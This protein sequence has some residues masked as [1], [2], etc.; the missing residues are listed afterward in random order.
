M[1]KE[2]FGSKSVSRILL[3]LFV[4]EKCYG[5][6]IQTLLQTSLT[7]VQ[8][9]LQRLEKD[10]IL[11]S[12]YEG[13]LR[14]YQLNPSYPLKG[15][16]EMLLKKA[17]RFLSA[18]EKKLY[19]FI[20]K[21]RAAPEEKTYTERDKK[22]ELLKFWHLLGEIH[23]LSFSAQSRQVEEKI[24]KIGQAEVQVLCPSSSVIVFQE[25]GY[26]LRDQVPDTAFNNSFRW[27]LDIGSSLISL[28]HLRYG[29]THPVFL[30]HL[31]PGSSGILE[32]VDAHLCAGDT[33]LGNISW[34]RDYIDF[35]WRV[36]GPVKNDELMY[37]YTTS[38][39]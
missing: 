5:G 28:E 12:Y 18:G 26:W 36:I 20:R 15:E 27:T 29:S 19:C 25:K 23:R 7:P 37:H 11:T 1:L 39:E 22:Q 30:F 17:Y 31:T 38:S 3:F 21:S 4:N 33:Y 34:G 2:L 10:G 35:Q 14:I 32:A 24:T 6:Q 8:K 9:A 16:L 13:K